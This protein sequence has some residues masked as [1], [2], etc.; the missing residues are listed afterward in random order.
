MLVL[1]KSNR[2]K[3]VIDALKKKKIDSWLR[4]ANERVSEV[5]PLISS[6]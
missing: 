6:W 5:E 2:L 1:D 3:V 4:N